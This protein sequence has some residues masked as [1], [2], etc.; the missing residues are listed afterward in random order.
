MHPISNSLFLGLHASFRDAVYIIY[1]F[2]L[3]F[4]SKKEATFVDIIMLF[5]LCAGSYYITLYSRL[6]ML[7]ATGLSVIIIIA[8]SY[9]YNNIL[10]FIS[11]HQ[12][13]LF[14]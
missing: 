4:S 1:R 8:N 14:T 7:L 13:V 6:V 3:R 5:S 10:I 9:L 11:H 2:G 12:E